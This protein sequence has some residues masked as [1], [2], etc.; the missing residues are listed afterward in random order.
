MMDAWEVSRA[1]AG[2]GLWLMASPRNALLRLLEPNASLNGG[3]NAFG[4]LQEE[5]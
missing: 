1:K 2:A 5:V 4:I 3:P